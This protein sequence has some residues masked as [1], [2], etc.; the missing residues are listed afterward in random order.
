[1]FSWSNIHSFE[2]ST[3]AVITLINIVLI[4]KKI[5]SS[6]PFTFKIVIII[7]NIYITLYIA[8]AIKYGVKL[9]NFFHNY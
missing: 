3:I 7:L 8:I 5:V 2:N 4:T 1:M 6:I 9:L